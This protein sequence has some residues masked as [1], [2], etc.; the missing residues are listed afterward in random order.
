MKKLILFGLCTVF[1]FACTQVQTGMTWDKSNF[2]EI[3]IPDSEGEEV[4]YYF[5]YPSF[6]KVQEDGGS[7]TIDI[8]EGSCKKI[9][10]GDFKSIDLAENGAEKDLKEVDGGIL[11][12]WIK[13]DNI[14]LYAGYNE[15]TNFGFWVYEGEDKDQ[16]GCA[17]YIEKALNSLT[18]VPTYF[19]DRYSFGVEILSDYKAEDLPDDGGV[20]LKKWVE[21][22]VENDEGDMEPFGYKVELMVSAQDN[23][24]GYR[25]VLHFIGE[26]YSGYTAEF[27]D[28]DERTGVYVDEGMGDE[29]MTHFFLMEDDIIYDVSIKVIS[30][31]YSLYVDEYKEMAESIEIF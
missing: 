30:Q 9:G 7:G 23:I 12:R 18:D 26:K 2:Y 10:F 21:T 1:L 15:E 25:D 8:S 5:E 14:I 16:L 6:A 3:G 19:N 24:V 22:E 4:V 17:E 28:L 27:T 11:E 13:D 20:L 29:A 31:Y